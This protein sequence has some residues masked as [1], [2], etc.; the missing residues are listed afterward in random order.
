[1]QAL[2][3]PGYLVAARPAMRDWPARKSDMAVVERLCLFYNE[4]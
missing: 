2:L 1:V 3:A 4:S